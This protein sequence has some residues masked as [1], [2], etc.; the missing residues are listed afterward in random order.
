MAQ[1]CFGWWDTGHVIV[2]EIARRNLNEKAAS[3]LQTLLALDQAYYTDTSALPYVATWM[4]YIKSSTSA[5]NTWHYINW[6]YCNATEPDPG[7]DANFPP[8]A[9]NLLT[10]LSLVADSL[11]L[12]SNKLKSDPYTKAWCLRMLTHLV[13]DLHQP[14]HN[15]GLFTPQFPTGDLGGNLFNI[16]YTIDGQLINNTHALFDSVAGLYTGYMPHPRTDMYTSF[17]LNETDGIV[18]D[19]PLSSFANVTDFFPSGNETS[20]DFFARWSLEGKALAISQG[21]DNLTVGCTPG[22]EYIKGLRVVLKKQ[23]AIGGYR[24]AYLLN[25]SNFELNGPVPTS[26]K[27]TS[28]TQIIVIIALGV[29]LSVAAFFFGSWYQRKRS[30]QRPSDRE[31]PFI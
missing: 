14:F 15:V 11:N 27:A 9:V 5:F 25:E 2:G 8:P 30:N 17:I 28:S 20:S 23:I 22:E 7:C 13:G 26:E 16:N 21:Y 24:L 18:K 3:Q 6:P 1:S 29:G 19:F 4:D 31:E 10:Q 12:K